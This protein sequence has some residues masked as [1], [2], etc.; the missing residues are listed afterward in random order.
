MITVNLS[1]V[2]AL[3]AITKPTKEEKGSKG[4]KKGK[5]K[6]RDGRSTKSTKTSAKSKKNSTKSSKGKAK[7]Q[8]QNEE[9]K[10]ATP[11]YD[12]AKPLSFAHIEY[13]L[14]PHK[15]P[16]QVDVK[17]WGPIAKVYSIFTC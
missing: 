14:F 2:L 7:K 8:T 3:S 16:C 5:K 6:N 11:E 4:K 9:D 12:A 13:R 1:L 17:C 10:N 15:L